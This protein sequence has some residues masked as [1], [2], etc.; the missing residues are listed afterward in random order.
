MQFFEIEEQIGVI[1]VRVM[2]R[3]GKNYIE[4]ININRI[5]ALIRG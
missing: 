3:T 4:S 5:K 2:G 1:W